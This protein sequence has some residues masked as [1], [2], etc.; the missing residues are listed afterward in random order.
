MAKFKTDKESIKRRKAEIK[1]INAPDVPR[2]VKSISKWPQ[3]NKP[4][5]FPKEVY[6]E[7]IKKRQRKR[8]LAW[9]RWPADPKL[10][11]TG[12]FYLPERIKEKAKEAAAATSQY[13]GD[14]SFT[15][16]TLGS[17]V[18][19]AKP[20]QPQP[21]GISH[22]I[23]P[24]GSTTV[25]FLGTGQSITLTPE[26]AELF[27]QQTTRQFGAMQSDNPQVAAALQAYQD[28]QTAGLTP[29]T[30]IDPGITQR[31]IWAATF[32]EGIFPALTQGGIGAALLAAAAGG[33]LGA[34]AG[35]VAGPLGLT[36]GAIVGGILGM[37]RAFYSSYTANQKEDVKNAFKGFQGLK[38]GI[39]AQLTAVRAGA[40]SPAQAAVNM[41][42]AEARLSYYES[43]LRQK[44][45]QGGFVADVSDYDGRMAYLLE[46][47]NLYYSAIKAQIDASV[48]QRG[49]IPQEILIPDFEEFE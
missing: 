46:Y 13:S 1:I 22:R 43:L 40:I 17:E 39:S 26:E 25:Q 12:E 49:Y 44:Q 38:T 33:K 9:R 42:Y 5:T 21:G 35:S 32:R 41:Q 24:D 6:E 16:L 28:N 18:P 4:M 30:L 20:I 11:E 48:T 3:G 10:K 19:D 7:E 27:G 2:P 45:A 29:D 14:S 31:D 23:N 8:E 15:P 36:G 34:T 47:R 37:A